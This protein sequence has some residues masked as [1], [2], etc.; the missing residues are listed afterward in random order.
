M[1]LIYD[2]IRINQRKIYSRFHLKFKLAYWG[3]TKERTA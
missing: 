1:S 3:K 2:L